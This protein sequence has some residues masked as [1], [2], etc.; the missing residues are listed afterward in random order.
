MK[1]IKKDSRKLLI[2]LFADYI[3]S[4]FN[5]TKTQIQIVD[6]INFLIIN[7]FTEKNHFINISKIKND[8][9]SE[10]KNL[11]S[12][13]EIDD[14]SCVDIIKYGITPE[15]KSELFFNFKFKDGKLISSYNSHLNDQLF[16]I[17]DFPYGSNVGKLEYLYSY[18]IVNHLHDLFGTSDITFKYS[19]LKIDDD[20]DIEIIGDFPV[21]NELVKSLVLD[22]FDFDINIFKDHTTND[23]LEN[24]KKFLDKRK[25]FIF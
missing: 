3:L 20:Y 4:A 1:V 8:F 5:D 21:D 23:L 2:N 19:N 10:Y 12:E 22:I 15:S 24:P 7:G 11:L 16:I 9:I 25:D 18:Y 13:N 6:C 14:F 17:S